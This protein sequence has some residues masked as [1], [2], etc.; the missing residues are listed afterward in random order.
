[1]PHIPEWKPGGGLCNARRLGPASASI[2]LCVKNGC[3][4]A[5]GSVARE[6]AV[7]LV[8]GRAPCLLPVGEDLLLPSEAALRSRSVGQQLCPLPC[9]E[10][11]PV[12]QRGLELAQRVFIGGGL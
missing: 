4:R 2:G 7:G 12:R 1:M 5:C 6:S 8:L 3:T 9:V 11:V 10:G